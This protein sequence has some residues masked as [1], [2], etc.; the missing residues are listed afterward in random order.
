MTDSGLRAETE[1]TLLLCGGL[2]ASRREEAVE[3]L[4]VREFN[5][6]LRLLDRMDIPLA[7]LLDPANLD[8]LRSD[9]EGDALLQGQVGDLLQRGTALA[10]ALERWSSLGLW[11]IDRTDP[12]Y[13]ERFHRHLKESAPP[14]LYGAGDIALLNRDQT[15]VAVVG[16]R[17]IDVEAEAFARGV[18]ITAASF[19]MITVSGGARGADRTA[20]DGALEH[21]GTAIGILP[22]ALEQVAL[23][24]AYRQ[25]ISEG[26]FTVIS[27]YHPRAKFTAGNAMG[28]N[29]LIYCLADVGVVV[30]SAEGSGGTWSGATETLTNRWVPVA[31]RSTAEPSAGISALLAR[32]A[33][34]IPQEVLDDANQFPVWLERVL[35]EHVAE[36]PPPV[37]RQLGLF[38]RDS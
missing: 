32:G 3:P 23:S 16:S 30:E 38:G 28:R 10:F 4:T 36:P 9:P 5:Q 31:V 11:V 12:R 26:Q 15:R 1:A 25:A 13:P 20:I 24:R 27:P 33:V 7:G 29:R 6:V 34:P 2:A 35:E 17:D 8:E 22:G 14:L 19:E 18:G 37:R 21:G